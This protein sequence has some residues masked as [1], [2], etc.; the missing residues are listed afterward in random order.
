MAK[1]DPA[2]PKPVAAS[3]KADA[4]SVKADALS[5]KADATAPKIDTR[6]LLAV[7]EIINE[8]VSRGQRFEV[9]VPLVHVGR[10]AHNDIV[11]DDDSV[12]DTH[13]KLQ[14]REDGWFL[15]DLGSTNGTYVGGSRLTSERRLDGAPDVRFGGV[16]LTFRPAD[17]PTPAAKS[18][19]AIAT[20][21][22]DRTKLPKREPKAAAPARSAPA[23]APAARRGMSP[24]IWI[25]ILVAAV[26]VIYLLK[27]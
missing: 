8:G 25:A 15:V 17:T 4:A 26:V 14:R 2:A 18:T 3:A 16:K 1:A 19:R 11:I 7:L 27:S 22:I 20:M 10:G 9:R 13:A 5:A 21:P 23:E 12:S 6:P 24:W